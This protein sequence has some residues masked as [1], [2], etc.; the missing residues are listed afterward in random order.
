M[1]A[2]EVQNLET[3]AVFLREQEKE[4]YKGAISVALTIVVIFILPEFVPSPFDVIVMGFGS[5]ILLTA[6]VLSKP[7]SFR[8]RSGSLIPAI[9]L[10]AAMWLFAAVT[11]VISLIG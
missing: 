7:A 3:A 2:S 4:Q 1:K 8:S 6:L 5:A 9:C 10:G 11:T